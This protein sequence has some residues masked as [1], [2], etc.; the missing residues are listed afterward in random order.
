MDRQHRSADHNW[1]RNINR[2]L[3]LS[4]L[5]TMPPQ[6]RANLAARTGLTRST[7]SSLVDELIRTNLVRETGI[8]PSRGGR[9]GTLL[10]LNP[11][12]GCAIGV[13]ITVDSIMVLLTDFVA[14]PRWQQQIALDTTDP[15]V[16]LPQA[17]RLIDEALTF[18]AR[19]DAIPPLGIGLGISGLVNPEEGVLKFSSNLGWRDI[20]LRTRLQQRFDLPV[21][22]GNEASIAAL[23]E[24]YFG[25]A[26]GYTD[27]IYL[28]IST[29]AL[30]AGIFV[31]G[32]LY[33]GIHGYA[34][35]AGHVTIDP[36]GPPCTCGKRGCWETVLR[37]ACT[38]EPIGKRGE[39]SSPR[40]RVQGE[41]GVISFQSIIDAAHAGDSRA[42]AA[43][44]RVSD[45]LAT[46]IANLVNMFN[47]QLIILGGPLGLAMGPFLPGIRTAVA[48]QVV[49]P[50]DSAAEI[51]LSQ[52]T[53]NACAMG[54]VA[55]VLDELLREPSW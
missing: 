33:Q 52:I 11:D 40:S 7:V 13:E 46:G 19:T 28:V 24:N 27:F 32:K 5:R 4:C 3:I 37:A 20:P 47:P 48:A 41:P 14:R 38:V 22:V 26:A 45:I 35:E 53:S 8:S 42:A 34:G 6:S 10:Q 50:T 21:K 43:V 36:A 2:S 25:A 1:M 30:G 49:V 16:V 18:N 31:N 15:D 51:K 54:A 29:T 12:G 55:L 17:E 9:P 39:R 44:S 23:G